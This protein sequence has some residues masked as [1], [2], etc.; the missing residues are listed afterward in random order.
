M[1]NKILFDKAYS[2]SEYLNIIEKYISKTTDDDCVFY[3]RGEDEDHVEKAL[4]PSVYRDGLISS[5]EKIYREVSR[6]NNIDFSEDVSTFDKLCRMQHYSAPT[7]LIDLSDDPLT[8]L[9]F[10][11]NEGK[12]AGVVY[13]IKIQKSKIKYSDSDT[14][15]VISNLAK[16]GLFNEQSEKSKQKIAED[17]KFVISS[18]KDINEFNS[19]P[20]IKFLLHEIRN[21]INHFEPIIDPKHISSIQC[22]K[23]KLT[24]SRLKNQKG[25][26]LLFGLNVEEPKKHFSLFRK[27][28]E[29]E[30]EY[31]LNGSIFHNHPVEEILKINV[32]GIDKTILSK[33]GYT[34]PSIYPEMDKVSEYFKNIYKKPNL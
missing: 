14:V 28:M 13:L 30:N 19:F 4:T 8:A 18:I 9:W 34:Q 11:I 22:V 10:A 3:F 26:F 6:Y 12:K 7:R 1:S 25:A 15:T 23:P 17:V 16:I 31:E 33:I 21:D 32:A 24:N 20:S 27:Q 5:E 29:S 2:I